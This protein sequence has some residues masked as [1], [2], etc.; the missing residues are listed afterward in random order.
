MVLELER[1]LARQT[2]EQARQVRRVAVAPEEEEEDV[3]YLA[4][5]GAHA[6]VDGP[7]VGHRLF[8]TLHEVALRHGLR[9]LVRTPE[10]VDIA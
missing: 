9:R 4:R 6:T 5:Q 7:L 8:E 10:R 2:L 1:A 3:E